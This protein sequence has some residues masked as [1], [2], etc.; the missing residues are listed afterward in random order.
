[1][2]HAKVHLTRK[3]PW[4]TKFTYYK[5]SR[6]EYYG[7]FTLPETETNTDNKYIETNGNLCATHFLSVSI[8]V[9]VSGSVNTLTLYVGF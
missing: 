9:S 6:G 2:L 7:A 5:R 3:C 1:M 8:S 4:L